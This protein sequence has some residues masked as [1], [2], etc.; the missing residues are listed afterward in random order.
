MTQLDKLKERINKLI[1]DESSTTS[2]I[3]QM[4]IF[5]RIEC[6]TKVLQQIEEIENDTRAD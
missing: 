4:L 1:N 3:E 6:Y 2:A 5:T